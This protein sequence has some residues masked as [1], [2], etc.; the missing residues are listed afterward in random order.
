M[1]AFV[2]CWT[3]K[4]TNKLYVG[5]HKGS[6]N[7]GYICSSKYMLEEYNKRPS[8]FT[9]QI[10]AEGNLKDIR[11]L[12]AKILQAVNAR[13]N[14]HFYNMHDNDGFYFDGWKKGEFSE[15]HR[16]KMSE[17]AKKRKR[18]PEHIAA[19]HAGRKA[20]KNSLEHTNALIASR[21]GT[22]HSEETRQKMREAKTKISAERKSE[23]GRIANA[24]RKNKGGMVYG[25]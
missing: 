1:E 11:I 25:D 10:I 23:I 4:V 21:K 22:K 14:E 5:S 17:A 20:S 19:L 6:A 7:D 13:L 8:D 2:Y 18:S 3:D 9:R 24:A 12:E 16:K 15:E